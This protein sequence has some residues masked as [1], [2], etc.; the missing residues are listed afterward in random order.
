MFLAI[1]AALPLLFGIVFV[2]KSGGRGWRGLGFFGG[3]ALP[4]AATALWFFLMAAIGG[5]IKG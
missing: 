4:V 3:V 1:L 5:A 2:A